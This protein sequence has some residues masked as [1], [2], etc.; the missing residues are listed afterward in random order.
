M[1]LS[2]PPSARYVNSLKRRLS[3]HPPLLPT[4]PEDRYPTYAQFNAKAN[5]FARFLSEQSV[6]PDNVLRFFFGPGIP[7]IL[8]ILGAGSV[9]T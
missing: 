1:K 8:A 2:T 7:Q 6:G 3:R 4:A 9:G 5:R